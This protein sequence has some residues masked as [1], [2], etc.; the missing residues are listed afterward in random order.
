[1]F[2]YPSVCIT[3]QSISC[4]F[5]LPFHS[6]SLLS[7][8]GVSIL[9][10]FRSLKTLLLCSMTSHTFLNHLWLGCTADW[11]GRAC[12]LGKS[13]NWMPSTCSWANTWDQAE[14]C[15]PLF[16]TAANPCSGVYGM[17]SHFKLHLVG[18]W[19]LCILFEIL[20][21]GWLQML[22]H[23]KIILCFSS[24]RG[25]PRASQKPTNRKGSTLLPCHCWSATCT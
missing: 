4:K 3:L 19:S 6:Y 1:M 13:K 20:R 25:P 22:V 24:F 7:T 15:V 17:S 16:G 18:F 8:S 11:E 5:C 14:L 9:K 2:L 21:V 10:N 23:E 12:S